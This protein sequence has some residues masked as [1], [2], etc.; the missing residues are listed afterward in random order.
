MKAQDLNEVIDA[1]E[2]ILITGKKAFA[3]NKI[4]GADIIYLADLVTHFD[5]FKKAIQGFDV[6]VT[7]TPEEFKEVGTKI[8]YLIGKLK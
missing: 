8:F 3:D 4:N 1:L 5:T 2:I 7:L 6:Q